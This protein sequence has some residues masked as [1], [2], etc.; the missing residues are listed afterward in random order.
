MN[1]CPHCKVGP[2]KLFDLLFKSGG[3]GQVVCS[4]CGKHWTLSKYSILI[5][6]IPPTSITILS[7]LTELDKI[8]VYVLS[9]VLGMIGLISLYWMIVP[10]KDGN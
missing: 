9:V 5:Y 4:S 3:G 10:V 7:Y 8:I 2:I 1:H 6:F